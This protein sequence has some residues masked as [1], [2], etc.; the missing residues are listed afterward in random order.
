[1]AERCSRCSFAGS[2]CELTA[3][4][5]PDVPALRR[6]HLSHGIFWTEQTSKAAAAKESG[7][8]YT[9]PLTADQRRRTRFHPRTRR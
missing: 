5:D 6:R 8:G 1:M 9:P 3:G 4:H 7:S 2:R